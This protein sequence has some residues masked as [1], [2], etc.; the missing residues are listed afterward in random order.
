MATGY[1]KN[2]DIINRQEIS[3]WAIPT[4]LALVVVIESLVQ[5]TAM[6]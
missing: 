2:D 1:I 4:Y 5:D 6:D 3:C